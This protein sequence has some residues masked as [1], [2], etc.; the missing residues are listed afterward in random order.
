M[1]AFA[2]LG[3]RRWP[4]LAALKTSMQRGRM[5]GKPERGLLSLKLEKFNL[6][7]ALEAVAENALYL[8]ARFNLTYICYTLLPNGIVRT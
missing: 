7:H 5:R 3:K 1:R 6:L 2:I 8:E 4:G